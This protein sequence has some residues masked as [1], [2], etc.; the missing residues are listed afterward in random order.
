M[1]ERKSSLRRLAAGVGAFALAA[2]GFLGAG[3]AHAAPGNIDPEAEGNLYVHK[4]VGDPGGDGAP[5]DGTPR[6]SLPEPLEGVTF[7]IQRISHDGTPVDL[8]TSEGWDLIN[9]LQPGDIGQDGFTAGAADPQVTEADGTASFE[10][11]DFGLYLVTETDSGTNNI[12]SK[13]EPFLVSVPFPSANEW[14]YDVHVY[15]KNVL[16]VTE[17]TKTVD[18][19]GHALVEGSTVTWTVTAPV[20]AIATGDTYKKFVITDEFDPRLSITEDDVT[21]TIEGVTLEDAD[22]TIDPGTS[23]GPTVVVTFT[24]TGLAKLA[25]DQ[26]VV[27]TYNTT[28]EELGD[29]VFIDNI[30]NVNTNDTG[31]DTTEPE[32]WFGSVKVTKV[33]AADA[34]QKLQGAEFELYGD[35]DGAALS[36]TPFVT[37]DDGTLT[38]EGLWV[39]LTEGSSRTYWL[40]E[41]KAPAGYITPTGE[42][43]WTQVTVT[44]NSQTPVSVHVD[45]IEN[46]KQPGPTLPLTGGVGAAVFGGTGLAMV[47]VA[48]GA[49]AVGAARRRQSTH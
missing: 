37:G 32:V 16:N 29:T 14:L 44:A 19:P 25:A 48:V 22:F 28:V 17:P 18:D 9:G 43:A 47:L 49:I 30:A 35:R 5:H 31:V 11:L 3:T 46:T 4:H 10:G 45:P 39:G 42:D 41:T 7:T 21:V 12:I 26:D 38:I 15:P 40:K 1:F 13:V 36:D 27:V 23:P 33:N 8:N 6:T 2:A 20:P 24:E 34:D